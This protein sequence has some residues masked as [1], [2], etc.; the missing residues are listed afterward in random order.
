MKNL[1]CFGYYSET[2]PQLRHKLESIKTAEFLDSPHPLK[3]LILR[4]LEEG[5][6]EGFTAGREAY[7]PLTTPPTYITGSIFMKTDGTWT[8]PAFITYFVD[9][10]DLAVPDE[11]IQEMQMH[12]FRVP[13]VTLEVPDNSQNLSENCNVAKETLP[14]ETAPLQD[15]ETV[16]DSFPV[17]KEE[18]VKLFADCATFEQFYKTCKLKVDE[19]VKILNLDSMS[20]N[21]LMTLSE[22]LINENIPPKYVGLNGDVATKAQIADANRTQSVIIMTRDDKLPMSWTE[23]RVIWLEKK[24]TR[25]EITIESWLDA[26]KRHCSEE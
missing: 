22:L 18:L 12:G 1:L 23:D 8:W 16:R 20:F 7:D 13:E 15:S 24:E 25:W 17:I 9:K 19:I 3:Y 21:S 4:Y 5:Q 10:Y 14:K 26:Y 11:L 6:Y 2:I